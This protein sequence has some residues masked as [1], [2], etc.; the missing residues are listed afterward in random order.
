M[1]FDLHHN[2]TGEYKRRQENTEE[3][4][5][6]QGKAGENRGIHENTAGYKKIQGN[7]RE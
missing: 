3:Y 1:S 4:R 6:M 7:I 2:G 5:G